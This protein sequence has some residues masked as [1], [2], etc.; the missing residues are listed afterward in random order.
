MTDL[1]QIRA[2]LTLKVEQHEPPASD[3]EMRRNRDRIRK[4]DIERNFAWVAGQELEFN[5][6]IPAWI[7]WMLLSS[8]VKAIVRELA[9]R[10]YDKLTKEGN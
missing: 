5:A 1:E 3:R 8:A 4:R 9:K 6:A 7:I 10:L 2:V